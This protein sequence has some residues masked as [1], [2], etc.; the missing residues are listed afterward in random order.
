MS[1]TLTTNGPTNITIDGGENGQPLILRL[2]GSDGSDMND[3]GA[4]KPKNG[5]NSTDVEALLDKMNVPD[6][7]RDFFRKI[8]SQSNSG[9]NL[10]SEASAVNTMQ[11][12]QKKNDIGLISYDQ[13]KGIANGDITELNGKQIPPEVKKAAEAYVA[14][15]GAL[16]DKV[17]SATDGKHDSQLGAGD[18]DHFDRSQLSTQPTQSGLNPDTFMHACANNHVS[19]N[20]PEEYDAVK[21]MAKFQKDNKI[22]LISY[23]DM[24]G[25]ANGDIKELNGKPIPDNIKDAAEVYTRNNGALFD[26]I[27]SSV[28]GKHDSQLSAAD[29]DKSI[30][31]GTVS[32]PPMSEKGAVDA[33]EKFQKDNDIGLI[34]YDQ[35]KGIASGDITK[36]N[37]KDVTPEA[38]RAAEAYVANNGALFDKIENATDGKHDSQLGAGDPEE[39]RKKGVPLSDQVPTSQQ[40]NNDITIRIDP[41]TG[42]NGQ[43]GQN[44]DYTFNPPANGNGNGNGNGQKT[45]MDDTKAVETVEKFQ[46]DNKIGLISYDEMKGI[47]NGDITELHGKT[48]TPE[49]KQAAQAY[50]ADNG[51]L[52]DK[53]ESSTD[54]KH[55]SQLGA[56][57]PKAARAK[58]E[59]GMTDEKAVS[60]IEDFQQRTGIKHL[61]QDDLIEMSK[62][63]L[64]GF[65]VSPELE[66]AAE[67]Y[68]KNNGELFDKVE[69]ATDGKHDSRLG[70]GD[71]EKAREK[72]LIES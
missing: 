18:P 57:D 47:A 45:G 1:V 65:K 41:P 34:S 60:T 24:K 69:S 59:L 8:F 61:S 30:K 70:A 21:D 72:D 5:N 11:Q 53:M 58:N 22:G 42:Q 25:I 33:M 19:P 67:Q 43:N 20:N 32:V 56:G 50:V 68:M 55:D 27:E 39:A 28:T 3:I 2:R 6:S 54:G 52:F 13:M 12:F 49:M 35:L 71:P 46:K 37:G 9:S 38:K 15:N 7:M 26:K 44:G 36:I 64:H 29:G 23:D 40:G 10:P 16:F 66:R 48:I 31:D 62:G 4:N 17:E 51:K 14:N 63:T